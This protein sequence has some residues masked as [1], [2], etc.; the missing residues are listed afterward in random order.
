VTARSLSVRSYD[1]AADYEKVGRFLVRTYRTTGGHINWPQPRW[2]YMHYHPLIRGVDLSAIGVWEVEGEVVGVV[3]PEHGLGTAYFEVDPEHAALKR[4]MLRYA[5]ER[6]SASA[7]GVRRLG[8]YINDDDKDFREVASR[9]GYV[10]GDGCEPMSYLAIPKPF[11]AIP[12]PADFRLRSLADDNDLRKVD[13]VLWRGFDHGDQ[14][15]AG[16]IEDRKFMQS[17]PNYRKDLNIIVE[18]PDGSFVSYCG[19][20]FEPVRAIAYVEPVATD[21][22]YRRMGLGGAAVLEGIRR[23]GELG[24]TVACVGTARPFYL[25]LGFRPAY[26]NHAWRREWP[27]APDSPR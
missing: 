15:P 18:A 23:C 22:G 2:E 14:P 13:R 17:A 21:P 1:R 25:S 16:G 7:G 20:W 19:M 10:Q 6:L 26:N 9:L 27:I 11:P 3:H 24:A 8:V 12:L 4:E 5:E